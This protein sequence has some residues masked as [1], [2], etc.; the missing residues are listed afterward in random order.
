[1]LHGRNE[2][3]HL[4]PEGTKRRMVRLCCNQLRTQR[5]CL[6]LQAIHLGD[7]AARMGRAAGSQYE[8]HI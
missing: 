2:T 6:R 1:M 8:L 4:L 5:S 3:A 7:H